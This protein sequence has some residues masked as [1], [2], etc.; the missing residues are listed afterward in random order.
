MNQEGACVA[1]DLESEETYCCVEE[2]VCGSQW[3]KSNTPISI[4]T[5]SDIIYLLCCDTEN[6][7]LLCKKGPNLL[8]DILKYHLGTGYNKWHQK[9]L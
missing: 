4:D 1:A 8:V 9:Q 7:A 6:A 3:P 5:S 2:R